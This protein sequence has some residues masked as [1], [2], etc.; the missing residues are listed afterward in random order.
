MRT[1]AIISVLIGLSFIGLAY[2]YSLKSSQIIVQN[3]EYDHTQELLREN[4]QIAIED[5]ISEIQN[6][7]FFNHQYLE[8]NEYE[9]ENA[10]LFVGQFNEN[11][12]IDPFYS[13]AVLDIILEEFEELGFIKAIIGSS[14]D[15]VAFSYDHSFLNRIFKKDAT[16]AEKLTLGFINRYRDPEILQQTFEKY[17]EE[18]YLKIP[19]S[20]Y[21]KVF[22]K[23]I[24]GMLQA[25]KNLD[26]QSDREAFFEDIYFKANSQNLHQKYWDYTF[27][28]R[29]EIEKNDEVVFSI[30]KDI[31]DHYEKR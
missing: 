17:K 6:G 29:R 3:E 14:I 25:H 30:L 27:W 24:S 13:D 21:K 11:G 2:F 8:L 12:T 7:N 31:Q 5:E 26:T 15:Y 16:L 19:K 23:T 28:K 4:Q 9:H 1:A 20:L 18:L 22:E 10:L